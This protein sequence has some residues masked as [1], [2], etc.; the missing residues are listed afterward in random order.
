MK[1]TITLDLLMF[2]TLMS[3]ADGLSDGLV[4][5]NINSITGKGDDARHCSI[6]FE[7]DDD[8]LNYLF[9]KT[10]DFSQPDMVDYTY[11]DFLLDHGVM[12]L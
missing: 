11:E 8:D 2:I 4:N 5:I 7:I 3:R 1:S 6:T 9:H 12:P 10:S